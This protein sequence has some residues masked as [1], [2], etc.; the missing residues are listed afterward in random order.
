MEA[1]PTWRLTSFYVAYGWCCCESTILSHRPWCHPDSGRR[2]WNVQPRETHAIGFE[3]CGDARWNVPVVAF[4]S[5]RC[6]GNCSGDR[7]C[8]TQHSQTDRWNGHGCYVRSS[9][10]VEESEELCAWTSGIEAVGRAMNRHQWETARHQRGVQGYHRLIICVSPR[11]RS[12][13]YDTSGN[14]GKILR[15]SRSEDKMLTLSSKIRLV[16][17]LN[18]LYVNTKGTL[19]L[20]LSSWLVSWALL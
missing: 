19:V 13:R 16:P 20:V 17:T 2:R 1:C 15:A 5:P 9:A 4:Q 8:N 18:G 7:K 14:S 6:T 10:L 3:Y 11:F 12:R